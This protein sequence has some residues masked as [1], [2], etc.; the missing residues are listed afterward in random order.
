M[1]ASFYSPDQPDRVL[2]IGLFE[3]ADLV[4]PFMSFP[5]YNVTR[6]NGPEGSGSRLQESDFDP[7]DNEEYVIQVRLAEATL[8][9]PVNIVVANMQMLFQEV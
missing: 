3:I 9:L 5:A 4:N 2:E 1:R 8:P 6:V 7:A